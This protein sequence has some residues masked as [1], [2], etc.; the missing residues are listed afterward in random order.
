MKTIIDIGEDS[1][2]T[3]AAGLVAADLDHKK[4]MMSIESGKYYGLDSI[5][6]RIWELIGKQHTVRELVLEL[7]KEYDVDEVTCRRD[8][9]AFLNKLNDQGLIDI[10]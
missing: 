8:L 7:V 9:L 3:H 2:V 5:G 10:V 6:S 4:V 1:V